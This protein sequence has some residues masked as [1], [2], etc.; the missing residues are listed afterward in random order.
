[1]NLTQSSPTIE[2]RVPRD[3]HEPADVAE[4]EAVFQAD[5][6]RQAA[7]HA[8]RPARR[9]ADQRASR[10]LVAPHRARRRRTIDIEGEEFSDYHTADASRRRSRARRHGARRPLGRTTPTSSATSARSPR[11]KARAHARARSATTRTSTPRR[12]SSTARRAFVGSENF[13]AGSLQYNRELGLI[14][15]IASE[16]A[17]G[18]VDDLERLLERHGALR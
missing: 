17:E 15:T 1:M 9:R 7:R 13:S 3:R 18:L 14:F 12:S 4:A 8:E 5:F 16:V 2:P 10:R 11:S 6:A